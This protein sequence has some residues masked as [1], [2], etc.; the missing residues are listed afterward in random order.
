MSDDKKP[1]DVPP[2]PEVST[3]KPDEELALDAIKKLRDLYEATVGSIEPSR[4]EYRR[5]VGGPVYKPETDAT[6][7]PSTSDRVIDTASREKRIEKIAEWVRR[8]AIRG[9][10]VGT[11]TDYK[12]TAPDPLVIPAA[13]GDIK[14]ESDIDTDT[15]TDTETK[16]G[17]DMSPWFVFNYTPFAT[18]KYENF[19]YFTHR[20]QKLREGE[21][22]GPN[23]RRVPQARIPL[24]WGGKMLRKSP[25]YADMD[26]SLMTYRIRN[27]SKVESYNM[28]M[29]LNDIA[30]WK[31]RS[32]RPDKTMGFFGVHP[33]SRVLVD[34]CFAASE[35]MSDE[36]TGATVNYL[37]SLY[38]SGGGNPESSPWYM[39]G[40]QLRSDASELTV[41]YTDEA[42]AEF[43]GKIYTSTDDDLKVIGIPENK[44][45][46]R[47]KEWIAAMNEDV[48]S[49]ASTFTFSG[50]D[51]NFVEETEEKLAPEEKPSEPKAIEPA[52]YVRPNGEAYYPRVLNTGLRKSKGSSD[53]ITDVAAVRKAHANG[54]NVLLLGDPGTGK[55]ALCEAALDDLYVV[56]C[57]ASTESS[58]FIGSYIPTGL[59]S[60]E[61]RDGPLIHAARE[62]KPLFVDEIALC[63]TRELAVLYSAMDGRKSIHV[64]ANPEVGEVEIKEGFY[65]IAACNPYAPGAVMSDA[66]LSR[67]PLQLT[68]T[69]DYDMLKT[70]GV[71]SRML[72]I[73]KNLAE[74]KQ[75]NLVSR[76][77]QTRELL[78]FMRTKAV[79]NETVALSAFI[80]TAAASDVDVYRDVVNST[81]GVEVTPIKV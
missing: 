32:D 48:W 57:D 30:F 67:F 60:F 21:V 61:W 54:L 55:T 29:A 10:P 39:S 47:E 38:A 43:D 63:D 26:R 41:L 42:G 18:S 33:N 66:L 62:G 23:I 1:T 49:D 8:G 78:S 3:S 51:P 15:D 11:T 50:D 13:D 73:G 16:E 65:V 53:E 44:P 45:V 75:S 68:V 5:S 19:D 71:D 70:L 36:S 14:I 59:D 79:F 31:I 69:T 28:N 7:H 74:K 80:A 34:S 81:Y 46:Y 76:A 24:T 4:Y 25:T 9:E 35:M 56:E 22:G 40:S 6:P 27:M 64:T 52:H 37:W 2:L 58:A 17:R 20:L 12:V 77:P 72:V